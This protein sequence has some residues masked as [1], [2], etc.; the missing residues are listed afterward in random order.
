MNLVFFDDAEIVTNLR[1]FT[2]TRPISDIRMGI[3]TIRG[4]W[5][6]YLGE[7][8]S[9]N[10]TEH[11]LEGK[12]PLHI[13]GENLCINSCV[14]PDVEIVAAVKDLKVDQ[15]LFKDGEWLA[16]IF[17]EQ[18]KAEFDECNMEP[19]EIVEYKGNVECLRNIWDIFSLCGKELAKDFDLLVPERD[20]N[21]WMD[22]NHS[23]VTV[24]GD[25]TLVFM[26][27]GAL[28]QDGC[29]LNTT[30]GPIY[31]AADS[32]I[33]EGSM[34][35]GPFFLGGHSQLKM[36][37]KIYGPTSIGPHCKVGGEVNNSVFFGYSSK[38]HDGFLGNSVIGEWC[39]LGADTNNSNLK[40]TYAEVKLWHYG[41]KSFVKTGLQFCGLIMGDHSKCG[42]NTMFNT[43]TVIGV[44]ANIFGDGFPRNYIPSFSW[45]G[46]AGFAPYKL[47]DA[48]TTAKLVYERRNMVFDDEEQ[49][50][51]KH[52]YCLEY[53][54]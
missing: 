35:R 27:D 4:K 52:L 51:F 32:E 34:V 22:S 48:I 17:T 50:I 20:S 39:N 53:P 19:F 10:Y 37:A 2:F 8:K 33:M 40:N 43:G 3:L 9:S 23:G 31:L 25:S 12:F 30:A 21:D 15:M 16:G 36:G 45:G 42:I 26:E 38:A 29:T 1:P 47:N 44:S 24:I 11:Y 7:K 14:L 6:K 28:V 46:A 41:K 54:G 18:L 49:S 13:K 5:H